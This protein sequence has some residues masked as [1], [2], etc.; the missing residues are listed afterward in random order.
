MLKDQIVQR[1]ILCKDEVDDRNEMISTNKNKP[2][3]LSFKE[4]S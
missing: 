1:I 3:E 2:F 4:N